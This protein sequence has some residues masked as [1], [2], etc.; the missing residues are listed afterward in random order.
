MMI[1]AK[2]NDSTRFFGV[3]MEE[4]PLIQNHLSANFEK[5]IKIKLTHLTQYA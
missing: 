5:I 2:S 1:D 4:L 3:V